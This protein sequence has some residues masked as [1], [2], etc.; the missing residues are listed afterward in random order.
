LIWVNVASDAETSESGSEIPENFEVECCRT[1]GKISSTNHVRNEEIL[2]SVKE[3]RNI[4]HT[5]KRRKASWISHFLCRNCPL[6]LVVKEKLEENKSDGKTKKKSQQLL[7]GLKEN[8]RI[9][10][11]GRG[12]IRSHCVYVSLWRNLWTS[13]KTLQNKR[14]NE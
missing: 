6:K 10:E 14:K 12:S 11:I 13:L 9:L 8:K 3:K 2:N 7:N 1:L 5:I 4:L